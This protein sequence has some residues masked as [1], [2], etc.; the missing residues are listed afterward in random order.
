VIEGVEGQL[1]IELQQ[2]IRRYLTTATVYWP[3]RNL[4]LLDARQLTNFLGNHPA[5]FAVP[6]VQ[7]KYFQTVVIAVE[8]KTETYAVA[9]VTAWYQV[10]NDGTVINRRPFDS[11]AY[12]SSPFGKIKLA[13]SEEFAPG[14]TI[15]PPEILPGITK[16]FA[17]F[18]PTTQYPIEFLTLGRKEFT[19]TAK[20]DNGVFQ[21]F[22]DSTVDISNTLSKLGLLMQNL[23]PEQRAQLFYIDMRV[24][25][26]G[27]VCLVGTPCSQEEQPASPPTGPGAAAPPATH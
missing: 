1:Q 2:Q 26:R 22:F 8:P 27:Y 5:V 20:N 21:V 13:G 7:K 15:L 18:Q 23:A 4:L 10:Y 9:T 16:L 17:D 14:Q 11:A 6:K 12:L 24:R 3:Q 25:N 19:A